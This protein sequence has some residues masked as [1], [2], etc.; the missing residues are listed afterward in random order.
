MTPYPIADVPPEFAVTCLDHL[1]I[2]V[3]DVDAAEEW[4][5]R[6]L[7]AE[8]FQRFGYGPP[9]EAEQRFM[10]KRFRH[11]FMRLGQQ[12]FELVEQ[13][14]WHGF[15]R[16]DP[17][18]APHYGFGV[19]PAGLDWYIARLKQLGVPCRGPISHPPL[20]AVAVYFCDPDANHLELVAWEGH[21]V[22]PDMFQGVG[23]HELH[24]QS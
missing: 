13:P 23:Y 14:E 8:P 5:C 6:V 21:E 15:N 10:A 24:H 20:P 7:G 1:G 18:Q 12:R 3:R 17:I 22:T 19:S 9:T 2:V 16:T 4:Y 11:V